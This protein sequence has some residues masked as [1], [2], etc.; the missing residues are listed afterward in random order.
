MNIFQERWPKFKQEL[1]PIL[2]LSIVQIWWNFNFPAFMRLATPWYI[3]V[4]I[5]SSIVSTVLIMYAFL[6]AKTY[7]RRFNAESLDKQS[8]DSIF[9]NFDKICL[10]LVAHIT[11]LLMW[12]NDVYGMSNL[13][14]FLF[15][16]YGFMMFALLHRAMNRE[17]LK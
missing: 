1:F 3:M 2:F 15:Y 9:K 5:C 12:Y 16:M 10:I 13:Q 14:Y 8:Y 11:I 17:P 4:A 7:P 6:C